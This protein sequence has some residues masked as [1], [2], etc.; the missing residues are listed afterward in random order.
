MIPFLDLKRRYFLYKKEIDKAVNRSLGSGWFILG[1]ELHDFE[2]KFANHLGV[3]CAVGVN[4]GTDAI[5][6]ALKALGV[7]S[8]DEVITVANTAT[9][10]V[11]AIRMAGAMPVFVDI[12]Q[13]TFNMDPDLIE[14]KITART[15][16]ILPVHLY[17]FPADMDRIVAIARK[18]QLKVVED[19]AQAHGASYKK[20][21]VGAIGNVGC[22]SFYPTKNLGAFGDAGAVVTNNVKLAETI[23]QL[24]NYGEV[25]KYENIREG[26]NSRLDEIQASI[27]N[28]GLAKLAVW[29]ERR[30]VLAR[31]YTSELSGLPI[32]LPQ[33]SDRDRTSAWHLFVIRCG[34]RDRLRDDLKD[35]GIE[36]AIHYPKPIFE[37][38]AYK[39]LAKGGRDVPVT[40]K[41]MSEIL[42]L[43]LYP[44]L[45]E[46]EIME[47]CRAVRLFY[48][49]SG[50]KK[51]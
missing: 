36:T 5:F 29:N 35:R 12:D 38:T 41:V 9:P 28:W 14:S 15:R 34:D 8:G 32:D 49:K 50:G 1:K 46:K 33:A 51:G 18:H 26:V 17:G 21:P 42:S 44:E 27:L 16:V 22:F 4:S 39:F 7:G 23:R 37:Q 48:K 2:E 45:S 31:I 47:V 43:P 6:L 13:D 20:K 40:K 10:T 30:E 3:R 24:R 19:A 11:S 25:S